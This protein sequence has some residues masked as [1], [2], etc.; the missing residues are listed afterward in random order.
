M[1]I[2]SQ[3]EYERRIEKAKEQA[4]NIAKKE[5]YE[6][7][8]RETFR[9]NVWDEF[10][11]VRHQIDELRKDFDEKYKNLCGDICN[12]VQMIGIVAGEVGIEFEEDGDTVTMSC[13][14]CDGDCENCDERC[15]DTASPVP[16]EATEN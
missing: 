9:R 5:A 7:R 2:L 1:K 4:Y 8:E 16:F 11:G 14:C 3:R 13:G 10:H 15:E 12:L 6:E